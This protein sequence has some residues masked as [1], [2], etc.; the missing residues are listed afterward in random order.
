MLREL[1]ERLTQLAHLEHYDVP[2]DRWYNCPKHPEA[3]GPDDGAA[4]TC[5]CGADDHNRLVAQIAAELEHLLPK[6]DAEIVNPTEPPVGGN[7]DARY[8]KLPEFR[9]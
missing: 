2:E 9:P 1:I 4:G 7:P 8:W 3:Q 5:N 6:A